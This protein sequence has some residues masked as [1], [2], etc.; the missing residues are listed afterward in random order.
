MSMSK[1]ALYIKEIKHKGT[2]MAKDG[3]D[4]NGLQTENLT[5][6]GLNLAPIK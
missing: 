4:Q 2:R 3:E 5:D 6:V 1:R